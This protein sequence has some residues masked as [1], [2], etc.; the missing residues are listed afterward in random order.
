M[1]LL[2]ALPASEG[3]AGLFNTLVTFFVTPMRLVGYEFIKGI[4]QDARNFIGRG[5]LETW[6]FNDRLDSEWSGSCTGT[7]LENE[8]LALPDLP[9]CS[10]ILLEIG[11]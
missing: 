8:G 2:F 3:A 10:A 6:N 11:R 7:D 1:L 4:P 5:E 9:P